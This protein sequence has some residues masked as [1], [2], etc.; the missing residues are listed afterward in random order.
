MS[1]STVTDTQ[2]NAALQYADHLHF[3]FEHG[4]PKNSPYRDYFTSIHGRP[5]QGAKDMGCTEFETLPHRAT[6]VLA[7][8]LRKA[9]TTSVE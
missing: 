3:S 2:I 7:A 4:S 1:L 6:L 8:A 9:N 5:S